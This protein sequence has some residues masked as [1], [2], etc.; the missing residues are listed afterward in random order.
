MWGC[1]TLVQVF[2]VGYAVRIHGNFPFLSERS[3]RTRGSPLKAEHKT[4]LSL[5]SNVNVQAVK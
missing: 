3:S 1:D 4:S 2:M 5:G